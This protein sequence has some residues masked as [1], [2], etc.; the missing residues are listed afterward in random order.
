MSQSMIIKGLNQIRRM[1]LS[2]AQK[3][4]VCILVT[5]YNDKDCAYLL[6]INSYHA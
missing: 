4:C 6:V 1:F 3:I 5:D 2:N